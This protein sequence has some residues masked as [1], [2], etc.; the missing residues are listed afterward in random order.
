MSRCFCIVHN[1]VIVEDRE[2][3]GGK[4]E[5]IITVAGFLISIKI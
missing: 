3:Q 5:D 4:E 1:I 2:R